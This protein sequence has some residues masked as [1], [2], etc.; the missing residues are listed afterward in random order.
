[1]Y[2]VE[3]TAIQI[4]M[5]S[6][7]IRHILRSAKIKGKNFARDWVALELDYKEQRKPGGGRKQV[8]GANDE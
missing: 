2:S 3:Y 8:K 1:M 5:H 6:T 4:D 7:Q